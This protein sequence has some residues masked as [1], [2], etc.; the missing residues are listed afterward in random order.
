MSNADRD[1]LLALAERC[2]AATAADW[3]IDLNIAQYGYE[4]GCLFGVN[5]DPILWVERN[6]WEPTVSIDTA[7]TLLPEKWKLRGMQFSAPCADDRK[8]HLNLHGGREGQ[9]RFVGRG[10]T[11]AL[12]MTA[13]ALRARAGGL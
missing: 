5:Y 4:A 13:A 10:A 9:D 8:W 2:E 6:C 3:A 11:P 12:A 7:M 1:T